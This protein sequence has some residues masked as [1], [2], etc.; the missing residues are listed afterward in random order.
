M[1]PHQDIKLTQILV[2]VAQ[3]H[4]V[5]TH[6]LKYGGQTR[7]LVGMRREVAQKARALGYSLPAIGW[8]LGRHHTTIMN[9]LRVEL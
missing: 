9:L 3:E 8:L 2:D 6:W 1:T 4:G 7:V 5:D